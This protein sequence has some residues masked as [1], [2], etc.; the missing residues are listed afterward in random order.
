MA[1]RRLSR[2]LKNASSCD[3]EQSE[4]LRFCERCLCECLLVYEGEMTAFCSRGEFQMFSCLS[5]ISG[6]HV[7]AHLHGHQHGVS[8]LC[9]ANLCGTF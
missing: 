4:Q 1:A 5:S 9:S 6:H 7:G 3:F 8:I 2:M